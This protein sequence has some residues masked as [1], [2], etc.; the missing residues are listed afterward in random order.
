MTPYWR[1]SA[2]CAGRSEIWEDPD[3]QDYAVALCHRCPVRR[4][5]LQDMLAHGVPCSSQVRGG[6]VIRRSDGDAAERK[7]VM[8]AVRRAAQEVGV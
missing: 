1:D 8:R 5:C 4:E 6:V 7:R 3:G 2:K